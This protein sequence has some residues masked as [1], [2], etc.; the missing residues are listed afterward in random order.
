M[1]KKKRD[2]YAGRWYGL[3]S[4]WRNLSKGYVVEDRRS[5]VSIVKVG[6]RYVTDR[7]TKTGSD[8]RVFKTRK[9]LMDYLNALWKSKWKY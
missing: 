8:E 9:R 4:P 5:G 6:H 3:R 1:A 7:P 2:K